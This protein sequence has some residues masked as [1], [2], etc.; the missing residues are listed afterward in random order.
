MRQ[1]L[2][3]ILLDVSRSSLIDAGDLNAAAELIVSSTM[4]GLN[5]QRAGI[6]LFDQ[7]NDGIRCRLLID[8]HHQLKQDGLVLKRAD[9]P[10]YF[11]ALD[12]DRK[13]VADNAQTDPH[14]IE[15]AES[16]LKPLNITSMLDCPIRH[17]G[18][19]I[20]ILCA[21]N[22]G[23]AKTWDEDEQHF[24]ASVAD[25][26]GRAISAHERN[27]YERKLRK[28]NQELEKKVSQRTESLS[29]SLND[30]KAMQQNLIESEKMAALGR[31]V[32]GI[33]HEVNT[34]IGV[35]VTGNS[36]CQYVLE[37]L[38]S[39]FEHNTLTRTRM[40]NLLNELSETM[41]LIHSNI[42]RAA[43]LIHNFKQTA[44]DQNVVEIVDFE[45]RSYIEV[46]LSSLNPILKPRAVNIDYQ[47]GENISMRSYPGAI[48]QI[49]TNLV[50][51]ACTHAFDGDENNKIT[52]SLVSDNT[53]VK[54]QFA[55]NGCGMDKQTLLHIFEPFFTTNR[56]GGGSGLG[57]AI[58]FNL[59]KSRLK[60]DINVKST[61]RKGT[62]ITLA[63]PLVV[64]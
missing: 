4:A 7:E 18:E 38:R 13:I 17:R 9:F 19:M 3:D 30:L 34:P 41:E 50:N 48:A 43:S 55:D 2:E 58:I 61:P 60:G 14:T 51:N 23:T 54:L 42:H 20:G 36:H 59:V 40:L 15:F 37:K 39:E 62:V 49:M 10:D 63:L 29:N 16:Y 12:T 1:I 45:L 28:S 57:M 44:V 5:I 56:S 31:L 33:S 47:A 53:Q 64:T 8:N 27:Q 22:I 52:L 26:F 6:W 25:L 24:C 46:V 21:E 35:A 11:A 32:A